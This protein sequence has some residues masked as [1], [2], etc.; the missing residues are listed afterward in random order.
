MRTTSTSRRS[1]TGSRTCARSCCAIFM[2]ARSSDSRTRSSH[3]RSN[4]SRSNRRTRDRHLDPEVVRAARPLPGAARARA[5]RLRRAPRGGV[6]GAR[7][8][9]V[10]G[11]ARAADR[12]LGRRRGARAHRG[13]LRATARAPRPP[14]GEPID[15]PPIAC[16]VLV[17]EPT[18]LELLHCHAR[19]RTGA[20]TT[21][22]DEHPG[23]PTKPAWLVCVNGARDGMRLGPRCIGQLEDPGRPRHPRR[24]R[25]AERLGRARP[26]DD[27]VEA[28]R[29]PDSRYGLDERH[30]VRRAADRKG[31]RARGRDGDPSR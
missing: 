31:S 10:T 23:A 6:E 30:P 20:F 15:L 22:P 13:T 24:R 9:R 25:V 28:G 1:P 8:R 14:R 21:P 4:A 11:L 17:D 5:P 18:E 16:D 27:H 29:A 2:P 12:E 26:R 7:R 3:L 19:E